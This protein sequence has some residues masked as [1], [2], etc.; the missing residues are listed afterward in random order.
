[1]LDCLI[2]DG[3]PTVLS[4]MKLL[5]RIDLQIGLAE[6]L[7]IE[8]HPL[9]NSRIDLQMKA[10]AEGRVLDVSRGMNELLYLVACSH[11]VSDTIAEVKQVYALDSVFPTA[12]TLPASKTDPILEAMRSQLGMAQEGWE[13]SAYLG[14]VSPEFARQQAQLSSL[15]EQLDHNTLQ[16]LCSLIQKVVEQARDAEQIRRI[17]FDMTIALYCCW[18]AA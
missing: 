5:S 12:L 18:A 6:A 17:Q 8:R 9:A 11:A 2:F 4:T 10:L 3:S 16:Y 15:A 7:S 14:V 1:M 13:R